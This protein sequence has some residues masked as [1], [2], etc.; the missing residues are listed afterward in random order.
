MKA[1]SQGV[2]PVGRST[3]IFARNAINYESRSEAK[4]RSTQVPKLRSERLFH[5]LTFSNIVSQRSNP[6]NCDFYF[7]TDCQRTDTGGRTR[8]YNVSGK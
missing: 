1:A 6:F 2:N 5:L 4:V 8:N 7:V 3:H